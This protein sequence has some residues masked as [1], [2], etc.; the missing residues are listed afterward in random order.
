MIDSIRE[1]FTEFRYQV[2]FLDANL[3]DARVLLVSDENGVLFDVIGAPS[4][5]ALIEEAE[6]WLD[7][8][9]SMLDELTEGQDG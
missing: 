7:A 8:E 1:A 3:G 6:E 4:E 5:A 2:E 9:Q